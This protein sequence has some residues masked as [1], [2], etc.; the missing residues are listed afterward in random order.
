MC[1]IFLVLLVIFL[2][3]AFYVCEDSWFRWGMGAV[4]IMILLTNGWILT[5]LF[6]LYVV[7]LI[8]AWLDGE[9]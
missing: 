3:W 6:V 8:A 7:W 5:V 9:R 1:S 4:L 2:I